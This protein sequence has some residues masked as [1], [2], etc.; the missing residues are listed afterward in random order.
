MKPTQSPHPP[1]WIGGRSDAAIKR[2]IKFGDAWHPNRFTLEW[3]K[4]EGIPK[5]EELAK[6]EGLPVPALCPRIRMNIQDSIITGD[7]RLPGQGTIEQMRDDLKEL[8]AMGAEHVLLDW[9]SGDLEATKDH[10]SGLGI[11]KTL[12]EEVIDLQD[13]TLR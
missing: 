12:A 3:L 10:E 8:E 9:Y 6:A 4:S 13:E 2:A 1:I 5:V 11:L 7:D